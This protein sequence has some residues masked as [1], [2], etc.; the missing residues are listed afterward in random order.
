MG[1]DFYDKFRY[2]LIDERK[3]TKLEAK[4]S[5]RIR[6]VHI[7]CD[8]IQH[9]IAD[10]PRSCI[11]IIDTPGYGDNLDQATTILLEGLLE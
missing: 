1:I 4:A 2:K 7:P 3:T 5:S 8:Y 9:N 11:N 6:I 10:K